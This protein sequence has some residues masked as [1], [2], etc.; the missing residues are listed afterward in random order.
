MPVEPDAFNDIPMNASAKNVVLQNVIDGTV[1]AGSGHT[2]SKVLPQLGRLAFEMR[3]LLD[4]TSLDRTTRHL[5]AGRLTRNWS[6][7]ARG[8][9]DV[10]E[11][12]RTE[13][14]IDSAVLIAL[15]QSNSMNSCIHAAGDA[16]R[17]LAE[18]LKRC[19]GVAWDVRGFS[20]GAYHM[21]SQAVGTDTRNKE[22][23]E[24][25]VYKDFKESSG[26]FK[27]RD[28][29]VYCTRASTPD[30]AALQDVLKL[31][32]RRPEQRKLII[33]VGDGSGYSKD[34]IRLLQQKYSGVMVIG[35]GIGVDLSKYFDQSVKVDDVAQ[36]ATASFRAIIKALAA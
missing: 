7:I 32:S 21:P 31:V 11:R 1:R 10:F 19:P 2:T 12:R 23:A 35:V 9:D 6:A 4:N 15:D 29:G 5:T 25:I 26:A 24:W 30:V 13:D 27:R 14:G 16:V 36:L 20:S 33:W 28:G 34:A 17:M 3:S 8:A 18:A 22:G